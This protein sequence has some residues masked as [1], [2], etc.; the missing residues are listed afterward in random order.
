MKL[1]DSELKIMEVL[2]EEGPQTASQL[3]A[4]LKET[5]G[6]SRNTTY[7]VIQKCI[8][9]GAIQRGE[10]KFLCVPLITRESVQ[11]RETEELIDRMYAG[12]RRSFFAA[13]LADEHLSDEELQELHEM[14]EKRRKR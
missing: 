12:S 6:W 7:T 1:F 8:K 14:I 11:I 9:K 13:L 5:I 10:P 4:R 2:W 3:A